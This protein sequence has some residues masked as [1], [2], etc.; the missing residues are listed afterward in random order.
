[1]K[2]VIDRCWIRLSDNPWLPIEI[3][4]GGDEYMFV[5]IFKKCIIIVDNIGNLLPLFEEFEGDRSSY[6]GSSCVKIDLKDK[7]IIFKE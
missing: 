2:L 5:Q 4:R 1:M 7:N 3:F 6:I